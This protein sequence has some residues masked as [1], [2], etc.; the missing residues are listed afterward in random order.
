MEGDLW[1]DLVKKLNFQISRK[2]TRTLIPTVPDGK[3][4]QISDGAIV[5]IQVLIRVFN[6]INKLQSKG[7][8]HY[9]KRLCINSSRLLREVLN[10]QM[11]NMKI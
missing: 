2:I 11:N 5:R 9:L 3:I 7:N 10:K 8:L 1:K 4:P 6:K